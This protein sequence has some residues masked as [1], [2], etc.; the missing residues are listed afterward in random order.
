MQPYEE[1]TKE[2]REIA[3]LGSINE[4]LSWDEHVNLPSAGAPHR[5]D[6]E[7]LMARLRHERFTSPRIGELLSKLESSDLGRDPESDAAANVRETRRDYTRATKL[8]ASLVEEMAKTG[9]LAQHA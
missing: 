7:A 1:F 6:Q 9:V 8:P 2:L 3:L 5:G 4:L